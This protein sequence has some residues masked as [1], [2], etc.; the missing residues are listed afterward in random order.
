MNSLNSIETRDPTGKT[1]ICAQFVIEDP[2]DPFIF[3]GVTAPN[4][5]YT[6]SFWTLGEQ[7]NSIQLAGATFDVYESWSYHKHTFT[8]TDDDLLIRF[9][10]VG[11][12]Y[13]YHLQL[14]LGNSATDW[15]PAP[16]DTEEMA[17]AAQNSAN[18]AQQSAAD[19]LSQ[20]DILR[21]QIS[22]LVT[23][24]SGMSLMTQTENGWSFNMAS[25]SDLL[26]ATQESLD[27]LI[28]EYGSTEAAL[29]ALREKLDGF[30]EWVTIGVHYLDGNDKNTDPENMRPCIELGE[31]DTLFRLRIT[32]TSVIFF[33]GPTSGTTVDKDGITTNNVTL[34]GEMRQ[35]NPGAVEG[36]GS[37][38]WAMR[39][40]GNYGLTWKGLTS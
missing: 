28:E 38:V 40:N 24:G 5:E 20:I 17:E 18:G 22:M 36:S 3:S 16:E 9:S 1:S 19:A 15:S 31:G 13:I 26:D 7:V 8:A 39:Q 6:L 12:Y 25:F 11:T 33:D 23:D 35:T 27:S 29:A 34:S 10:A 14:E 2:T 37:F 21:H 30:G 4:K 32:N